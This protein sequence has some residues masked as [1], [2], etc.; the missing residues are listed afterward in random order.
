[1]KNAVA[2]DMGSSNTYIYKTGMGI[3]LEQPSAVALSREKG[4]IK[5]LGEDAKKL[6]GMAVEDTE[7]TFPVFEGFI[8]NVPLARQM[9]KGYF[10]KIQYFH[11]HVVMSVPCGTDSDK[12]MSLDKFLRSLG[13][14]N[15]A[16][17]ESPILTAYGMN[18][19]ADSDCPRFIINLGGGTTNISA[20]SPSG[21]ITGVSI[22]LG[23]QNVD[24]MLASFIENNFKLKIGMLTAEKLKIQ[25]GSMYTNDELRYVVNGRD[26]ITGR[27]RP[28]SV[29]AKDV[30]Q[31][32]KRFYDLIINVAEKIM[33]KLPPEA[34]GEI[35]RTG[36]FLSGGMSKIVGLQ[37]YFEQKL[38]VKTVIDDNP[39]YSN[40][41]GAGY[42]CTDRKLLNRLKLN[43]D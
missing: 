29:E 15:V 34:L 32:L 6:Y 3:V 13:V 8:D 30:Y 18:I 41:S 10:D 31:P 24:S 23:G 16:F 37:E 25:L 1:M 42:L 28:L 11:E 26:V 5:A 12:I 2:L 40:V 38:D 4:K 35:N 19:M 27:P 43:R 9:L 14:Y 22:N 36:I 17:V 7:V 39:E 20:V 33:A 21:V